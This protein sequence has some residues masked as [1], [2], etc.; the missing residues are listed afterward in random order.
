MHLSIRWSI[1]LPTYLSACLFIELYAYIHV[2]MYLPI[3]LF[4][5]LHT[6]QSFIL[7]P[8]RA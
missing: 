2:Y 5:D 4:V 3:Y 1:Y 6:Y 7:I 8:M